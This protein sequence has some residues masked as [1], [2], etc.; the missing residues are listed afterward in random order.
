ML[1]NNDFEWIV[2][3]SQKNINNNQIFNEESNNKY[4]LS[5][6]I[7]LSNDSNNV[8]ICNLS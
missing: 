8:K 5:N 4:N 6:A 7:K 3:Q 1:Y 2:L